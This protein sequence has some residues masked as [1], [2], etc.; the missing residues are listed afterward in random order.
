V[1]ILFTVK[2]VCAY[3]PYSDP[4]LSLLPNLAEE[5]VPATLGDQGEFEALRAFQCLT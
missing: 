3:L 1:L 2:L 5:N 4:L